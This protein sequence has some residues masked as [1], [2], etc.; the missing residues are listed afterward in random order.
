MAERGVL[1]VV[2][3][4]RHEALLQRS[5]ASVEAVHPELPIHVERLGDGATLLDKAAMAD[6]TPFEETVFL[7]T[8]TIVLDRLDFAF[9]RAR[10]FGLALSICECPW[11]RRYGG[12]EGD[13]VE[14]NTGVLFFTPKAAA[15]FDAWKACVRDVDSSIRFIHNGRE[16]TMPL[17][18]Q[19]GFAL[20]VERTGAAPFVLP[21]NWNFRPKWH[22]S[23]FGPIKIWHDFEPVPDALLANNRAQA[24]PDA[25]VAMSAFR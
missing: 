23:W 17:N 19:A 8:D 15:V 11:A 1:Y 16:H 21:Y 12:I 24:R 2:W 25:I 14:Y 20:A 13:T 9:D 7:D 5:I 22:L 3:G 4:T 6:M 18:D 10:A